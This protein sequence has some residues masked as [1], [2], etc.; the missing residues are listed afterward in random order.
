MR[1]LGGKSMSK[2]FVINGSPRL[3]K[4]DTAML[5]APFIQGMEADGASI[6]LFY[7]SQMNI[8]PCSCGRMYCWYTNPGHCCLEDDMQ[9]VYPLLEA[10]DILVL[11]TPVYIPLPGAM[12]NFLNRLCP[13]IEP[14]LAIRQGRTRAQLHSAVA[15]RKIVL[16]STC[17]WWE[18]ENFDTLI[19][20]VQEFAHNIDVDYAGAI[21]RPHAYEMKVKGVLTTE[22]L[23]IL[24]KVKA[25]GQGLISTGQLPEILLDQIAQPLIDQQAFIRKNNRDS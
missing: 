2:V 3:E 18:K 19:R 14:R 11:A 10:A 7:A 4:G 8:K 1:N 9:T 5:L 16:L 23:S 20:I 24:E 15:I 22:G 6:D 21:L 17:R 13:L 25:V 12:A